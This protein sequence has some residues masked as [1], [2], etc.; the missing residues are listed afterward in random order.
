MLRN[1]LPVGQGAFYCE[2]F[3][4]KNGK[5]INVVY[6]CGSST[7]VKIVEYEII[8]N[9][10]QG[11][12]IHALFI[13][14]LDED[15]VNGIPFLLKYCNV[16]NVFYTIISDKDKLDLKIYLQIIDKNGFAYR[17]LNEPFQTVREYSSFKKIAIYGIEDDSKCEFSYEKPEGVTLVKSVENVAD[18]I[19]KEVVIEISN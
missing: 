13:S 7:D 1:F 17:F 8:N 2:S 19:F 16:K 4:C 14:R 10:K 9:F 6:D 3:R 11:E 12:V 18:I 5:K 15:H